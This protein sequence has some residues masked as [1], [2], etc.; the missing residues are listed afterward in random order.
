MKRRWFLSFLG[1]GLPLLA[2][3][4]TPRPNILFIAVD[5]LRP[6]LNC[7]GA[8]HMKTP[9]IDK[10]AAD[11]VQFDRAYCQQAVC[12][13]SRISLFTGM[14]PESTGVHDLQTNF[15]ETI[16]DAATLPQHLTANGYL[17][18]GM[19]K[20]FHDEQWGDWDEWIDTRDLDGVNEYHLDDIVADLER[21]R[22][23]AL[24]RGVKPRQLWKHVK[25]PATE[26]ADRP[27]QAYH[28]GA[29]TDLAIARLRGLGDAAKDP[30]TARPFFMTVG[31]KKP[32][33]PFI[34]P[35]RYWDLYPEAS[36]QLPDNPYPPEGAPQ[37]A[38]MTWGE[39]RA[40]QD[41]PDEGPVSDDKARELI[42]GYYACVSFVDAQIGRLLEGLEDAGLADNTVVVL[43][44]D[45]GWK[46][47]EHGMWCKHTNFELDTRVPLIVRMPG[48]RSAGQ[49]AGSL[50]ELIDL[51]PTVCELAGIAPPAQC[52]GKSLVPVLDDPAA[53]HR[54]YAFSQYK[55]PR[56]TGGD[57]IG[58]SVKVPEGRFTEWIHLDSNEGRF[59]E[60][61]DHL[62][63]PDENRNAIDELDADR[64]A[65]LSGVL[66]RT[67][68]RE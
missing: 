32:H 52:E 39:L 33:L 34:A 68:G 26:A 10:L 20:V 5:D 29:M 13:P 57:F 35:R 63:D 24:A 50:V 66:R 40:Y 59:K 31:Y 49:A 65:D 3:A 25:G 9:H 36:I 11:G 23:D 45:H 4:D 18:I 64:A 60:W 2:S 43:W 55:R 37:I 54:R 21:Q 44:G 48:G 28:D 38:M 19:G 7:Y 8:E 27:D 22:E 67:F 6:E 16:P 47:G 56:K 62:A 46:L 61:Y 42:R 58:Y 15:R 30:E 51:Y 17:T 12:L 14:R 1:I 53:A 41:I